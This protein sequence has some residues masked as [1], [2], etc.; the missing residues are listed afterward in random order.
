MGV[1]DVHGAASE[2]RQVQHA[3]AR[4]CSVYAA[5]GTGGPPGECLLA[6]VM[7]PGAL[8]VV[9]FATAVQKLVHLAARALTGAT[10]MRSKW[11][12]WS[13]WLVDP[14]K[15]SSAASREAA[16]AHVDM[17]PSLMPVCWLGLVMNVALLPHVVQL[18]WWDGAHWRT[19]CNI[20]FFHHLSSA[21]SSVEVYTSIHV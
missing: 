11:S 14:W 2:G 6:A 12:C 16:A 1:C 17:A 19:G 13:S 7:C 20:M 8:R 18:L 5:H 15:H 9:S 21:R 3:P 4:R 10:C